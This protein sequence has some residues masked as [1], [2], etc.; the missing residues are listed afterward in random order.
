MGKSGFVAEKNASIADGSGWTGIR[1]A[2]PRRLKAALPTKH[3][4]ITMSTLGGG[5]DHKVERPE[6][7]GSGRPQGHCREKERV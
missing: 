5:A 4:L 2:K 6:Q 3:W 1:D 7:A